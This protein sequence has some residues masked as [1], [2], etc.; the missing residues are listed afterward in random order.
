MEHYLNGESGGISI[1]RNMLCLIVGQR[2]S[3]VRS[4]SRYVWFSEN[5]TSLFMVCAATSFLTCGHFESIN[6]PG[7]RQKPLGA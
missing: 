6:V 7:S 2:I 3:K 5:L 1:P 4:S